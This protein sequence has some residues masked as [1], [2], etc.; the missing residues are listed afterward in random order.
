[1]ID[2]FSNRNALI[3]GGSSG[4]GFAIAKQLLQQGADN[5]V[6]IGSNPVKLD[7]ARKELES[8]FRGHVHAV[9]TNLRDVAKSIEDIDSFLSQYPFEIDVLVNNAGVMCE[10]LFPNITIKEWD[11]VMDINLKSVFFLSEYFAKRMIK[12]SIYG[13]ILMVASSSSNRPALNPYMCSKWAIRGLTLGLAKALLPYKIIVNGIAP[14]PTATPM[15]KKDEDDLFNP[16]NPSERYC[17][18]DEVASLAVYLMGSYGKM[19]VGE[20]V[21]ISGGAATVTFDD[22]SY[23][24]P[25]I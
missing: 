1:M 22:Q 24:L 15:L 23:R 14:G 12:K 18:A 17:T 6:I 5:V 21:Y 25:D 3:T 4:I 10:G 11:R 2:N 20:L 13:N 16:K 9:C 7:T 8:L 19:V